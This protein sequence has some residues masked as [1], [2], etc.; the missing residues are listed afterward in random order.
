MYPPQGL[1]CKFLTLIEQ[2]DDLIFHP[3]GTVLR[4]LDLILAIALDKDEV[5]V[6]A[7]CAHFTGSSYKALTVARMTI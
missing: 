2:C 4:V 7:L 3:R 6:T 1:F 5:F